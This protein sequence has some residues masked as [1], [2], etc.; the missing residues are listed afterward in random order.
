MARTTTIS[1]KR[2]L[3]I[4]G[5]VL[6]TCWLVLLVLGIF[7]K[8]EIARMAVKDT[9]AELELLEERRGT[10]A[11]NLAELETDRGQEASLRQNFGVARPGEEVIIVVPKKVLTPPPELTIWQR[12]KEAV[13]FW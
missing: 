6:A 11:A 12:I 8:Q 3:T 2:L 7:K 10:L 9:Q 5:L 4:I 13:V 1:P